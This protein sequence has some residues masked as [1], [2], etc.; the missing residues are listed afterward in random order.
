VWALR[1]DA[2][3]SICLSVCSSVPWNAFFSRKLSSLEVRIGS[4]MSGFLRSHSW[5]H[6]ITLSNTKP[7]PVI[8]SKLYPVTHRKT[9][10]PVPQQISSVAE[11]KPRPVPH[12]KPLVK[13]LPPRPVTF[14]LAAESY[15]WCPEMR[16]TCNNYNN[17]FTKPSFT[18]FQ[19]Y[20]I[21]YT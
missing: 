13:N 12:S 3:L 19:I 15:S 7:R 1:D 18:I 20:K 10:H 17:S 4:R 6:M 21:I 16:H 8:Y 14:M 5:T 2:V 11:S 9:S